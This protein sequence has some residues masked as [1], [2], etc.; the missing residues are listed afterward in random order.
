[1][2][3]HTQTSLMDRCPSTRQNHRPGHV[4]LKPSGHQPCVALS[5]LQ[6]WEIEW[7]LSWTHLNRCS[8][9]SGSERGR[10]LMSEALCLPFKM[11]WTTDTLWSGKS[12]V[13]WQVYNNLCVL[14]SSH[15]RLFWAF[16][17]SLFFV[18]LWGWS[19]AERTFLWCNSWCLIA[20]QSN[21]LWP[22]LNV[23]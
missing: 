13:F 2:Q 23:Y 11:A 7:R 8:I 14:A 16:M 19:I 3:N 22:W 20:V 10:L 4:S 6:R 15:A 18:F 1:M 12:S 21:V 17:L 9:C 5:T